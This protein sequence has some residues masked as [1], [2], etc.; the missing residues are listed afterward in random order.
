MGLALTGFALA[1]GGYKTFSFTRKKA[2]AFAAIK[3]AS[4]WFESQLTVEVTPRPAVHSGDDYVPLKAAASAAVTV[5]AV[6]LTLI[7]YPHHSALHGEGEQAKLQS[8]ATTQATSDTNGAVPAAS[9]VAA[10][11]AA[12]SVQDFN[13][14]VGKYP[15]DVVNDK[16]FRSA[17]NG[18]SR[19]DWKKSLYGSP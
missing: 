2:V 12:H 16:R 17:F 9:T 1:Y 8:D 5:M 7:M 6:V 3:E 13:W 15:Y 18:I 4:E 10:P 14:L 11:I 19:A